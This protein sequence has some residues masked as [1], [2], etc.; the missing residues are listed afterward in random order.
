MSKGKSDIPY[1][2][3]S[4]L[5]VLKWW[6][7]ITLRDRSSRLFNALQRGLQIKWCYNVWVGKRLDCGADFAFKDDLLSFL[8]IDVSLYTTAILPIGG[9]SMVYL[10]IMAC[11]GTKLLMYIIFTCGITSLQL[12][13][14]LWDVPLC[15]MLSV[16]NGMTLYHSNTY[17]VTL[18]AAQWK[19]PHSRSAHLH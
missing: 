13:H 7:S 9:P 6:V 11:W 19:S 18:F 15:F 2:H 16:L 8:W 4:K 17:D 10:Y 5:R 1:P 3:Q 14:A 12:L